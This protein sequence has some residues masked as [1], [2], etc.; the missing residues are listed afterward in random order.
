MTEARRYSRRPR[1]DYLKRADPRL[2]GRAV[3]SQI[4]NHVVHRTL[5]ASYELDFGIRPALEVKTAKRAPYL[6][7]AV[8]RECRIEIVCFV[9]TE[10]TG[11][12]PSG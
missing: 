5:G 8:L 4:D 11:E 7:K 9:D 10:D 3:R 12:K 2:E 6:L 1:F